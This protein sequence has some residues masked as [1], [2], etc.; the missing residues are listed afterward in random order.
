MKFVVIAGIFLFFG[1]GLSAQNPIPKTETTRVLY[2]YEENNPSLDVWKRLIKM[3]YLASGFQFEE[4]SAAELGT[5]DLSRYDSILI[6]GAVMVFTW[7]EPLRDWL[8]RNQTFAGRRVVLLVT[9]NQWF[10]KEYQT[11]LAELLQKSRAQVDVVSAAT[12]SLTDQEKLQLVRETI[13][14]LGGTR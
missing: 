2:V 10:L 12:K 11:R 13:R 6:H 7:K 8:E 9:A 1:I 14:M 5:V 4:R 3:E